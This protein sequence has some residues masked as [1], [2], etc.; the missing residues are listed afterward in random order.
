MVLSGPELRLA[1]QRGLF[2]KGDFQ[3]FIVPSQTDMIALQKSSIF[4]KINV[5]IC[6]EKGERTLFQRAET[7][8]R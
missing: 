7:S 1:G 6:S 5:N 8:W 2:L 3:V 4:K